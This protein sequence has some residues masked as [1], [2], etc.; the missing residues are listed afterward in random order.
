[1][2]DPRSAAFRTASTWGARAR[3]WGA[4]LAAILLA[5]APAL[6]RAAAAQPA[7]RLAE[8]VQASGADAAASEE[9]AAEE[10]APQATEDELGRGTPRGTVKGFLE[11]TGEG[12]YERAA[13]YL[14]LSRLPPSRRE[15]QGPELARQLRTVLEQTLWPDP[16]RLSADAD[17]TQGDGLPAG[18]D[19]V[20]RIDRKELDAEVRL[21]RVAREDGVRIWKF[22]PELVSRVPALYESVGPGV[23]QQVLP[24][25]FFDIELLGVHLWQWLGLVLCVL[26]AWFGALLGTWLV[27]SALRPLEKRLAIL[28]QGR[29]FDAALGPARLVVGVAA[30]SA[31]RRLL[32]LSVP[33]QAF[34]GAVEQ[35][36]VVLAVAWGSFRAVDAVG[37]RLQSRL[38]GRGD[39][40]AARLVDP[41]RRAIKV[42][43]VV[44]AVIGLLDNLGFE[45]TALLAG[46]G[47]GG[48]AVALAGQK[49]LENLFGALTI[50]TDRPVR[51]GDF[52]RF[53]PWLGTV[54]E[55][56]LRSTRVRT[57]DRTIVSIPNGEFANMHLENFG[58]RDR[59]WY[60][61]KL[62]VRYETT[63]EQMRYLLVRIREMLY[64]HPMVDPDPARVRFVGFGAYSLD[65][66]IFAY[67]RTA[68]WNEFLGV[69]EDLN[70]RIMDRVKEAGTGFA[71]PSVTTYQSRDAGLDEE[72]ARRAGEQVEAWRG[73]RELPLPHFPEERVRELSG[74]LD[75]PPEGSAGRQPGG[76][77]AEGPGGGAGGS[78][79]A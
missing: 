49:S 53:G 13:G 68:D 39:E 66:E 10:A 22:A 55:I 67:V 75:F 70:L 71:F 69:A 28:G 50:Y 52:G 48:V 74:S 38:A 26:L 56:G 45:V 30:F 9:G 23:L 59:I 37:F 14:D 73:R 72:T 7:S 77:Q 17:G 21:V 35:G 41:G 58:R 61:R 20:G 19:R 11:A 16:A 78:R 40:A 79:T 43:V 34:V 18:Q 57:L 5:L 31:G 65:L 62:G 15:V 32:S 47:L 36:L 2:A 3:A 42:L 27:R 33:A 46:L 51:V 1:V 60:Y 63:P 12:D 24:R 64:G 6:P 25:F 76:G 8:Q 44:L 4:P 54:E 29:P